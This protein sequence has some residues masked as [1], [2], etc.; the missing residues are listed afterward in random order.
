MNKRRRKK[1]RN[2]L[3]HSK[4]GDLSRWNIE[5][6]HRVCRWHK[7]FAIVG[8]YSVWRVLKWCSR[9]ASRQPHIECDFALTVATRRELY[10]YIERAPTSGL[11]NKKQLNILIKAI[12]QVVGRQSLVVCY[13]ARMDSEM[14]AVWQFLVYRV[15]CIYV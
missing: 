3:L 14:V 2:R 1:K 15:L 10:I 9:G 13:R 6:S 12:N 11:K 4:G 7:W 8:H 5:R